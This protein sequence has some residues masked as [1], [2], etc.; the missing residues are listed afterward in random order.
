MGPGVT[1]FADQI[2]DPLGQVFLRLL[3]F[4]VV[5]LVFASLSLGV[6]QLG[7]LDRLGPLAGRTFLLFALNMVIG[8]ALGLL[9]MNLVRPGV[10]LDPALRDQMMSQ[11]GQRTEE[12]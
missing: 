2:C 9:M 12:L 5:P 4:V 11:F 8:V 10:G 3:F 7:R 1:W 6:V